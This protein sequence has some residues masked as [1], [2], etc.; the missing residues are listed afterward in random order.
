M[1]GKTVIY[2]AN[3]LSSIKNVQ[4]IHVVTDGKV[5]ETGTHDELVSKD[6]IYN[7]IWLEYIQE[8]NKEND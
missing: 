6:S 2:V 5:V 7:Q 1:A 8:E 3:R 4:H